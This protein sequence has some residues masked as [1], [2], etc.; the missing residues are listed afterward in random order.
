MYNIQKKYWHESA[1]TE[2]RLNVTRLMMN[3]SDVVWPKWSIDV[4]TRLGGWLL[5]CVCDSTGWFK[6]EMT[7]AGKKSYALVEPTDEYLEIQIY[8]V[9]LRWYLHNHQFLEHQYLI[10]NR[11]LCF[12]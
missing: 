3:R 1:G 2:Q 10:I 7:W 6:K 4:R 8:I 5:G 9:F 12:E 11:C